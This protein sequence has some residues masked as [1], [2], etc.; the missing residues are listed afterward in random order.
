MSRALVSS[1]IPN[2]VNGVSQQ[3]D[4]IRLASQCDLQENAISS[5]VEGLR[6]R[7]STE[8]QA[9]ILSTP[10]T[11]AFLHT[12]N[13]DVQERYQVV[14]TN[15][16]LRVFRLNG[17]EVTVNFP[18]GKSYL[19]A[20]SPQ[21]AF[22]VVTV[23]DYTFIVNRNVAVARNVADIVPT[24][25]FEALVWVRSGQYST[26]YTVTVNA[27]SK[28]YTT[29]D[30]SVAANA[31]QITTTNIANQLKTL[32]EADPAWAAQG[33]T[34][35]NLGSTLRLTK[36]GSDFTLGVSD[37]FGDQ[38]IKIVKGTVQRFTDLPAKALDDF[39]VRIRGSS[40]SSFDD[41][42]VEYEADAT[43]PFG[44]VWKES[45]KPGEVRSLSAASM[46]HILV[47]E[48][49]GSF[50]FKR[51]SWASREVGDLNSVPF[52]SFDGKTI[53]DVFFHRNRLGFTAD[54]NLVMSRAGEFFN[55]FRTSAI[56]VLDDDPIDVAVSHVKVS[57]LRHALPFN[58]TLLLFSD[59]TQF[60]LSRADILSPKTVAVNQTTEFE[61]SLEAK[62]VGAG[63]NVYFAVNRGDYTGIREYYLDADTRTSDAAD[64][65]AHCPKYIPSGVVKLAT[66]SN[67]EIIVALSK[68]ER[69][70]LYVYRYYF[71][72]EEKLQ[73]SWSKWTFP[74]G[75]NILNMD[76]IES[77]LYIVVSR[78]DG[79]YI[80]SMAIEP[81]AS[82]APANFPILL[83]RRLNETQVTGRTYNSTTDQTTFTVPYSLP[84]S[85]EYQL[86]GWYGNAVIKPGRNLLFT[87]T[88][89]G[90]N[91]TT[92]TVSG[93]L[94]N[95]FFGRKFTFRYRFSDMLVRE[96][97]AG[98]GQV[99]V[100]EGRLQLR[101]MTL[102]F[103]NG[104]YFRAEVTPVARDTYSYV[105]TG[106]V[107]GEAS[108]VVGDIAVGDG[109]FT[110]PIQSKNDQVKIELVNDTFL[111]CAFLS[112]EW[113]GFF[114]IRSRRM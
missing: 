64:I 78:A 45:A 31:A 60:Q 3:P 53:N 94:T 43:S 56:Q 106:R 15:G 40:D 44:G 103:N 82:D 105:Y 28:T 89:A 7:P 85:E 73:S 113:E 58:E 39:K 84:A 96:Q 50:T 83:D 8:H 22:S 20:A 19:T 101:N 9:R 90:G 92:I 16:D 100:G 27:I 17:Q 75:D 57:I 29:P 55:F 59:Q 62:P 81:G 11:N 114:V 65:T 80:E 98:G 66:T 97:A 48:S 95:F 69:N 72:N 54:E 91:T 21:T 63:A 74:V 2:L 68:N 30:A 93:N 86:C 36:T 51:A 35:T 5:V 49:D 70:A 34:I 61:C 6:K 76:F 14:I 110:F 47:R 71:T 26:G 99:P 108:N 52:P 79:V 32:L 18:D 24:R 33:V 12:I 38:A 4:A 1:T 23:A 102:T 46:P 112:A 104:G 87:A 37:G 88:P 10:L 25:P 77:T 41:Y 13:R 111:P 107:I 67:E 42:W 109:Q